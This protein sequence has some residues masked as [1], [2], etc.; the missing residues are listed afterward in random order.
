MTAAAPFHADVARGPAGGRAVWLR[1][2]DGTR[3]RLGHWP[4]AAAA[5]ARGTVL[6]FPG[7]A[8][9][10]EKY[11]P[12]AAVLTSAGF[13]VLAIDWRGQGLSDRPLADLGH[14]GDFA[15]FQQ[16]VAAILAYVAGAGLPQPLFLL[17]HSMGGCI[18]LR[19]LMGGLA[20]A[21]AVFSA[22]MW[23][24]HLPPGAAA[25]ARPLVALACRLGVARARTPTTTRASYVCAAPFAGNRLTGDA[26]IWHWLGAQLHA[27]PELAL[28]G[29][30]LG[31]LAAALREMAAL[32]RLPS[33]ALPC[34]IALGG[35][36]RVVSARAIR[37]RAARWPGAVLDLYPGAEHEVMMETPA[38][39]ALF[40]ARMVQAF[41]G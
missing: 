26:E 40:H 24:L 8:E 10:V 13:E 30:T 22:P 6:V 32:R 1:A 17:A 21:G 38:T 18:G 9:H 5:S 33:P 28:G 39:R 35:A 37:A 11:G 12:A 14:V 34:R 16:D 25:L 2:A 41:I 19:S 27:H 4:A 31:W 36:E 29:P 3:L 23:G 15:E 7:Q 20:V